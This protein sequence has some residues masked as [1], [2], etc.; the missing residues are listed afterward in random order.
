[1]TQHVWCLGMSKPKASVDIFKDIE[2]EAPEIIIIGE[3]FK[4]YIIAQMGESIYM[5][6]K[7][8]AHERIIFNSLKEK[9]KIEI[10][11]LLTPI[12]VVLPKEEY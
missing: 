7:H 10:Q 12:S 4:T 2:D 8:A 5:I 3:A 11:A 6:D 1:M 9:R